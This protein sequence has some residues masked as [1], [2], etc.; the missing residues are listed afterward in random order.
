[1][2]AKNLFKVSILKMINFHYFLLQIKK[3]ISSLS[4]QEL[5]LR[6]NKFLEPLALII[7][8]FPKLNDVEI[9]LEEFHLKYFL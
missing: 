7:S 6:F 8:D 4:L 5:D 2:I 9:Y 1:M 3:I